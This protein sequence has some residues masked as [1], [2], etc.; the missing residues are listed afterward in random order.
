MRKTLGG[1]RLGTEGKM[2]VHLDNYG[3]S[4]HDVGFIMKTDQAVGTLVPYACQLG[5]TGTTFYIDMATKVRTMPTNGAI[6]GRLKHQLDVFSIPIRLYIAELHNNALGIGF[7]MKDVK[8]PRLSYRANKLDFKKSYINAQQI[9]QDSL[10]AYLGVRGLGQITL[11]NVTTVSRTFPAILHAGYWDIYKNYYANKQEGIGMMIAPAIRQDIYNYIGVYHANVEGST[12]AKYKFTNINIDW[13]ESNTIP[14]GDVSAI[15][16]QYNGQE[17]TINDVLNQKLR[18]NL[19]DQTTQSIQIRDII[20]PGTNPVLTEANNL[21][22]FPNKKKYWKVELNKDNKYIFNTGAAVPMKK[23]QITTLQ[24]DLEN[25][26]KVRTDLLKATPGVPYDLDALNLAPYHEYTQNQNIDETYP[27]GNAS[28]FSQSGLGL[29]TYLSDRFENY[30]SSETIDG[31]NG[32]NELTAV[33]VVDGKL[34]MDSLL[35]MKKL[36]NMMNRLA[37][38][39]G[40]WHDWN[41]VIYGVKT[42]E[43]AESPIYHGGMSSEVSFDEVVSNAATEV[44][45]NIE[46]LGSIAA[47]GSDKKHKGGRSLKIKLKEPSFIM[48]IGSFVPRIDYSQ[49]NEW[50]TMIDNMDELHKPGLDAIGFQDLLAEEFAAATT[51]IDPTDIPTYKAVG[52]QPSWI[53]YT[54]ATD[55]TFGSFSA[56]EPL[57]YMAFNRRYEFNEDGTL[58]T[59]STYVDPKMYNDAFAETDLTAKNLWVQCAIDIKARRVMKATQIPNL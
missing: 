42:I 5:T 40:T 33:S 6:F 7:K 1:D 59:A 41:Q 28:W 4:T 46:P 47:R 26:D 20:K 8:F 31:A 48:V 50:W 49:G 36:Y 51:V 56:E 21:S 27:G 24:F 23:N 10:T 55:K 3:R 22:F 57:S 15:L 11:P 43:M 52:K 17:G 14:A 39:D 19:N 13:T 44:A 37:V 29:R 58:K 18:I 54:T 30:L 32:V 9:S 25:I 53:E 16:I 45:G 12:S 34:S 35:M 38:S 2:T